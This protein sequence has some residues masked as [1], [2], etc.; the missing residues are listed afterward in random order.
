M[1]GGLLQAATGHAEAVLERLRKTWSRIGSSSLDLS[2]ESHG[3]HAR[4]AGEPSC[5]NVK[6]EPCSRSDVCVS[7]TYFADTQD[8]D[9]AAT[10]ITLHSLVIHRLFLIPV[11]EAQFERVAANFEVFVLER[12]SGNGFAIDLEEERVVRG[13]D[14]EGTALHAIR[15]HGQQDRRW[16]GRSLKYGLALIVGLALHRPP[17]LL[18]DHVDIPRRLA[19]RILDPDVNSRI[20]GRFA[21]HEL[22]WKRWGADSSENYRIPVHLPGPSGVIIHRAGRKYILER[23]IRQ[24]KQLGGN[25]HGVLQDVTAADILSGETDRG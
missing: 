23:V 15:S 7:A 3:H 22:E 19:V 21:A 5:D 14:G 24:E 13:I 4:R 8:R 25:L 20:L 9:V 2:P 1:A 6:F 17:A 16:R 12:H 10:K 18:E 11:P